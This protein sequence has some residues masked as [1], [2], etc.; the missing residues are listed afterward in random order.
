MCSGTKLLQRSDLDLLPTGGLVLFAGSGVL[1]S[2]SKLLSLIVGV[3]QNA[4]V[5]RIR[6]T[7]A[8]ANEPGFLLR[9][10]QAFQTDP[11]SQTAPT[12]DRVSLERLTYYRVS[13]ERLTYFSL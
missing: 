12:L 11:N 7:Q 2:G 1:R 13:L 6:I 9:V 5:T 8:R 10:G 4:R 3:Q